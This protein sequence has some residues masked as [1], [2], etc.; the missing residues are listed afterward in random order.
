MEWQGPTNAMGERHGRGV[1]VHDLGSRFEG[2]YVDGK[3]HGRWVEAWADGDRYEG[4]YVEGFKD[5]RWVEAEV[6]GTRA[7]GEYAAGVHGNK[8]HGRWVTTR[9]DGTAWEQHWDK[10]KSVSDKVV[11]N[12]NTPG[13]SR[14]PPRA[15]SEFALTA[16]VP[17]RL[18]PLAAE[19]G[20]RADHAPAQVSVLPAATQIRARP[21]AGPA[22]A[23]E[24]CADA[25]E[26][27]RSLVRRSFV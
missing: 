22:A 21:A 13:P 3:Q 19:A 11:R 24:T 16:N 10:G 18:D 20:R 25:A 17:A 9:P 8:K 12:P 4:E 2:E 15:S 6:D 27:F 1:L 7:E 5:G 23:P 26:R 14:D